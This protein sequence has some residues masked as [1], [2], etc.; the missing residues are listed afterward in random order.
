MGLPFH[1]GNRADVG[2][3]PVGQA[4]DLAIDLTPV[5]RIVPAGARLRVTITGADPRQRNLKDIEQKPA[6][7][8]TVQWGGSA[9]AWVELPVADETSGQ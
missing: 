7:V 9:A 1:S 3:L 6:P 2:P 8:I 4:A 5:S